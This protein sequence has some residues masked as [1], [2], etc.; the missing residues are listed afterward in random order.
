MQRV[1]ICSNAFGLGIDQPDIWFVGHVRPIHD[2]ENYGQESGRAGRGGGQ[3]CKAVIF[4]GPS[5]QQAL[6]Q[7]HK[8]QWR[9][10]T[11][12]QAIITDQD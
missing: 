6:Q 1:I 2:I 3:P 5:R 12:N 11:R 10:P 9:E 8:R 4:A 7:Q